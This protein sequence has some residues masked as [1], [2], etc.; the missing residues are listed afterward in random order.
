MATNKKRINISIPKDIELT[1]RQLAKRDDVPQ[2]TKAV[3]LLKLAIEIDEDDTLNQLAL[4][5][6]IKKAK[7]ISHKKAWA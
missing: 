5:R 6:D 2:A 4:K 7:F 3:H 1:L